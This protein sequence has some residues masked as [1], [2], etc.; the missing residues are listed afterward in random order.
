M[1]SDVNSFAY[2]GEKSPD[3]VTTAMVAMHSTVEG[4]SQDAGSSTME[5]RDIQGSVYSHTFALQKASA[6]DTYGFLVIVNASGEHGVA[7]VNKG[8]V[9]HGKLFAG[10]VI[11]QV[12]GQNTHGGK[13]QSL[14][15]A[16]LKSIVNVRVCAC[17]WWPWGPSRSVQVKLAVVTTLC[18]CARCNLQQEVS[19]CF[20]FRERP[21][22]GRLHACVR[23]CHNKHF[24]QKYLISL[25]V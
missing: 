8:S 19:N 3:A 14:W 7:T 17:H 16:R 6:S 13:C 10:D 15:C 2:T 23:E 5:P 22:L 24:I 20:Q 1:P 25:Q 18:G 9:A 4:P 11:L 21:S 12:N